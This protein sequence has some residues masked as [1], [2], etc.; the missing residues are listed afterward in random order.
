MHIEQDA[1]QTK[2]QE[3]VCKRVLEIKFLPID[4]VMHDH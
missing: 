3:V 2:N 4:L 1:M